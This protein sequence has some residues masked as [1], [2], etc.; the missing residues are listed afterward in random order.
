MGYYYKY[1][2]Y[3]C[4]Y[5]YYHYY[6]YYYYYYPDPIGLVFTTQSICVSRIGFQEWLRMSLR[7][8]PCHR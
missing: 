3:H 6:Y 5:Y 4:Y 1:Y 7:T 2:Y 8:R